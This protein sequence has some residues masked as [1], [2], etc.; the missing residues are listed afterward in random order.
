[1]VLYLVQVWN[2]CCYFHPFVEAEFIF[3]FISCDNV[4]D[5]QGSGRLCHSAICPGTFTRAQ[6]VG[7]T[8]DQVSVLMFSLPSHPDQQSQ[9]LPHVLVW[10][11]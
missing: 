4:V 5:L 2:V 8:V 3:V 6:A 1:M 10:S 7:G 9:K 11:L